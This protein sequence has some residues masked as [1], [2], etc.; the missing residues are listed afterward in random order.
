MTASKGDKNSKHKHTTIKSEKKSPRN[1]KKKPLPKS[2]ESHKPDEVKA[3]ARAEGKPFDSTEK[4]AAQKTTEAAEAKAQAEEKAKAEKAAAEAKE[5]NEKA[6]VEAEAEEKA[7]AE[8]E[9]QAAEDK[10]EAEAAEE[11][12]KDEVAYLQALVALAGTTLAIL[13]TFIAAYSIY[14][15]QNQDRIAV[16]VQKNLYSLNESLTNLSAVGFGR[17]SL[18]GNHMNMLQRE[19]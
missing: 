9:P 19:S 6:K 18:L 13:L 5:A 16:E 3:I 17:G 10:P 11:K 8:A 14:S 12:S 4:I 15:R 1:R 2:I 7:K